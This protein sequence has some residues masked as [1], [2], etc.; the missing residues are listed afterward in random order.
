MYPHMGEIQDLVGGI[1]MIKIEKR[2][3]ELEDFEKRKIINAVN[4]AFLEVDG[5]L[6]ETDTAADIADDIE[7]IL[8]KMDETTDA[9]VTVEQIQDLVEDLLM[10]SERRDV[11]KSYIKY[12]FKRE[13]ARNYK[14]DFISAIEQKLN[15]KNVLNQN[16]NVDEHSFGGRIG[17]ASNVLM[18]KY[19]L[20]YCVSDKTKKNHLN[21]RIYIHD[22]NSY[23]VGMHNC[24]S[25]PI[26]DLAA[27]GFNTRQTDVRPAKSIN[28][29]CQLCA[30]VMQLQ[31]LQQFGGVSYTHLDW[32]AVPYIRMSFTKHLGDGLIYIE[33][34][35]EY[36]TKRFSKWLENDETHPDGT[37]HFDDE[38]FKALHPDA[39]EYAM[40]MTVK[41]IHQAVEGLYHNLN[42]LQ[43]RSGN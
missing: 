26:D 24:L 40:D 11:A 16:A 37:I 30:V 18:E 31:S 2:T 34:R 27:K 21:N 23:A 7:D 5:V 35:S 1:Y 36:K 28:T 10:R 6:Y 15:A 29:F 41:E 32:S 43:S 25:I 8:Y 17:E 13:V 39:W 38:E 14:D 4:K 3:G 22:L 20:D 12:R 42:T 33:K 9:P 19:A